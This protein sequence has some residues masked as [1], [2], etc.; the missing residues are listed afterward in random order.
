MAIDGCVASFVRRNSRHHG[1]V[2][3]RIECFPARTSQHKRGCR[4]RTRTLAFPRKARYLLRCPHPS[5]ARS[6]PAEAGQPFGARVC[7][8]A[9]GGTGNTA[10]LLP[11]PRRKRPPSR[12]GDWDGAEKV[13]L[14]GGEGEDSGRNHR[15]CAGRWNHR[16]W[17]VPHHTIHE[18]PDLCARLVVWVLR[19]WRCV[20][21][22]DAG[23]FLSRAA[24]HIRPAGP[25]V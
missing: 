1:H 25:A 3:A 24:V 10:C 6:A 19:R 9:P 20:C 7:L 12:L 5:R 11:P 15:G 8:C 2:P 17:H 21:G 16:L 18:Q 13:Q 14:L 4:P 22:L 23:R